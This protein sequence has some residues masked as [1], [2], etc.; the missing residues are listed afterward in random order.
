M[1]T[2]T[3]HPARHPPQA[4]N[5][6]ATPSQQQ[7][8]G[9][10]SSP[11]PRSVPSPAAQRS[12]Q[13][14]GKSPFNT[15][16]G[17]SGSA[18]A[19]SASQNHPSSKT[20]IGSSPAAATGGGG[21]GGAGSS[22]AGAIS[23]DSPGALN[24]GL[25]ALAGLEGGVGMGISMSGMSGLGLGMGLTSSMGGRPDDTE[26]RKRLEAIIATL[27]ARPG[28][29]SR[30]GMERLARQLGLSS[31][32][33]SD[34]YSVAGGAGE[35][36][37]LLAHT[38]FMLDI[39]FRDAA[40]AGVTL[41]FGELSQ[42]VQKH[43]ASAAKVFKADLEPGP[44][45]ASINL[46][47]DRFAK[48]LEKLARLDH[49]SIFKDAKPEVSCFEAIAGV[50]NSLQKLFE[51]E[52]KAAMHLFDVS[53]PHAHEKATREVLCKKSGR[54]RMNAN[55]AVGLSLEYWMEKRLVFQ[56][57]DKKESGAEDTSMDVDDEGDQY[58][59]SANRIFS[60]TIECESSPAQLYPS[61]RV[62]DAWVSDAVEKPSDPNDL[63]G[64]PVIDWLDPPPTYAG[65]SEAA[66]NDPMALDGNSI[67]KLPNVRFVAKLNPPLVVPL[68][69]AQNILTSVNVQMNQESLKWSTSLEAL[70][71]KP[72]DESTSGLTTDI[73]KE[74]HNIRNVFVVDKNG[75]EQDRRHEATLYVNKA[76][77]AC[78]L[79][80]IPFD[81][82]RQ[83]VQILP[84]L[85]QYAHLTSLL[86]S[87]LQPSQSPADQL[88][89]HGGNIPT[90]PPEKADGHQ[91]TLPISIALAG[92]DPSGAS[93]P[94][95]TVTYP[96]PSS[97]SASGQPTINTPIESL[98]DLLGG[99]SFSLPADAAAAAGTDVD[100]A[101]S[102]TESDL[103]G[104]GGSASD[105]KTS[106]ALFDPSAPPP[107][108]TLAASI[109]PN[110]D[111]TIAAQD[112]LPELQHQDG[113][114]DAGKT[115]KEEEVAGAEG[116]AGAAEKKAKTE[117]ERRK[118]QEE[119]ARRV[120]VLGRMGRALELCGDV[121]VWV[122]WV[123]DR[124]GGGEEGR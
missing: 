108:I 52:K 114:G 119:E 57:P 112:L 63:F 2:P 74:Y 22:G 84:V 6:A 82:P 56:K 75:K 58:D 32:V 80:E 86:Q 111:V 71:L 15:T 54:P 100:M 79:D 62:S 43:A 7:H 51:H 47:L 3:N 60:L 48:N 1:S 113:G 68:S 66:Q 97:S 107:T 64:S 92:I 33:M 91:S 12:T 50:Y 94:I 67:G 121:G 29:V 4:P 27:R 24:I 120:R 35:Q 110:A 8:L 37:L 83:L 70:V 90:P 87:A 9:A 96:R 19:A 45:E 40:V 65:G 16:S 20:L 17:A 53:K 49:L 118:E 104:D 34:T 99:L 61:M 72:D 123:G 30:E 55:S 5:A 85:R 13:Q 102:G 31:E 117:E 103:F 41:Q 88:T 21:G 28:R 36:Q 23:F 14:A 10:F 42:G 78:V 25:N 95:L 38:S 26:Q 81:H 39:T 18:M 116:E 105:K 101:M 76:E 44:G 109:L 73:T 59:E 93:S 77:V 89:Q 11:A 115:A 106:P 124:I 46:S 98:D 69:T 122:E